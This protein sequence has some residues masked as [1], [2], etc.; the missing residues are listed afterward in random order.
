MV[1]Q[2]IP[3]LR[4]TP[5]LFSHVGDSVYMTYSTVSSHILRSMGAVEGFKVEVRTESIAFFY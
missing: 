1:P 4:K 3:T 2:F 5:L